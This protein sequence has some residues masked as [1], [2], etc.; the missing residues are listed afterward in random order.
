MLSPSPLSS[1][2]QHH[3]NNNIIVRR[4]IETNQYVNNRY[5]IQTNP[6]PYDHVTMYY[7]LQQQQC[8]RHQLHLKSSSVVLNAGGFEWDDP[9]DA[10]SSTNMNH[11]ENPYKN[12]ALLVQQQPGDADSTTVTSQQQLSIDPAR[13]LSPRLNGSNL[14]LIGMMGS[15]KS[16]IAQIIARRKFYVIVL[17]ICRVLVNMIFAFEKICLIYNS[18]CWSIFSLFFSVTR[19]GFLCMFRYR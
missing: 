7:Q 9:T 1:F 5:G 18:H 14:Y 10:S 3:D 16:T 12:P 8:H 13:L 19:D 6:R 17:V 11:V 2:H 15:G 4:M